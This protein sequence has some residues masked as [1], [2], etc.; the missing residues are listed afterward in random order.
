MTSPRR[1]E[2]N[3]RNSRKSCGPRTAAGK[4]VA[5]ANALKHGLAALT[6]RQVAPLAEVERYARALVGDD[7]DPDLFAQALKIAENQ[8]TLRA[9][10]AEKVAVVE[11]LRERT[12]VPLCKGDNILAM[13]KARVSETRH[14]EREIKARVPEL[15]AKYR[16]KIASVMERNVPAS[17]NSYGAIMFWLTFRGLIPELD[18]LSAVFEE[19]LD[20]PKP[21]DEQM[22][23]LARREIAASGRDKYEALEAA[24]PDLMR[25]DRYE[26][27]AWS[28]QKRAFRE[29]MRIKAVGRNSHSAPAGEE[30]AP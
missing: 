8:L 9:I 10:R 21:I 14:A 19:L 23:E 24:A 30:R 17:A 27:R 18:A 25:L 29:F 11:R 22:L 28:R 16:G 2:A 7:S 4:S 1:I 15:F 6:H 13:A 20:E 5:S 26:R 3:R 12:A